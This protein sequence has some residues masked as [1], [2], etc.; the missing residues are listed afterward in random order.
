[1]RHLRFQIEFAF[2]GMQKRLKL[3]SKTIFF[4]TF[5]N[6]VVKSLFHF[7][8]EAS[9]EFNEFVTPECIDIPQSKFYILGSA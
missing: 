9:D 3:L 4:G 1:M 5:F 7:A 6:P 2:H 8:T